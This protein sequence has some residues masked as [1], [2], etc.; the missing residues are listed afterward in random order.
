MSGLNIVRANLSA[1]VWLW[2]WMLL[3]HLR[4][5]SL[6]VCRGLILEFLGHICGS[7]FVDHWLHRLHLLHRLHV[8]L[9]HGSLLLVQSSAGAL[10]LLRGTTATPCLLFSLML[11]LEHWLR[12]WLK[13]GLSDLA[14]TTACTWITLCMHLLHTFSVHYLLVS[15]KSW[16]CLRPEW[17]RIHV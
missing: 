2:C 13:A 5:V 16:R 14:E 11:L 3:L 12:R 15:A 4:M 1:N 8:I 9:F 7:W 10:M 17:L 6:I